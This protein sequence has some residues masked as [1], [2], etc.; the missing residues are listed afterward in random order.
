MPTV[1]RHC[2]TLELVNNEELIAEYEAHHASIWPEVLRSF[3]EA[4]I[5]QLE[6]YRT[7]TTVMMLF[8]VNETFSFER[9]DAID[10]ADPVIGKWEALMS[11]YQQSAPGAM[12][13][14]KWKMMKRFCRV[15]V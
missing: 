6:M 7:G 10:R 13:N 9:K 12:A 2:F 15:V 8:E 4:G 1:T 3:E 14:E 11:A 5:L